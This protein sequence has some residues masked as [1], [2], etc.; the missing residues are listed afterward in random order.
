[1]Q[2]DK[3][4]ILNTGG[5]TPP[6]RQENRLFFAGGV[7]APIRKKYRFTRSQSKPKARYIIS[8]AVYHHAPACISSPQVHIISEAV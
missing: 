5:V 3:L 2:N 8:E 1:M 6:L 7:T 4:Q